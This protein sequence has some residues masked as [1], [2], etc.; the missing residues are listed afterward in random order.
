MIVVNDPR[1]GRVEILS[2]SR[3]GVVHVSSPSLPGASVKRRD[4]AIAEDCSPI[5][6][7]NRRN[8]L[9]SVGEVSGTTAPGMGFATRRSFRVDVEYQGRSYRLVPVSG[10]RSRFDREGIELGTFD[11]NPSG[12]IGV[13]WLPEARVA[14]QE[15][16]LGYSLV[17]A[18]GVGAPGALKSLVKHGGSP[19]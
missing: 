8:L 1:H 14:P 17:G 4:G 13:D 16:A 10:I 19:V 6:T 5:G 3:R 7:R 11:R 18:F 15:A 12:A 9:L 2:D